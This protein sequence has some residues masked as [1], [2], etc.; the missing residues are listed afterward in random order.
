MDEVTTP[1]QEDVRMLIE[2]NIE[3]MTAL[4]ENS[5][6][7]WVEDLEDSQELPVEEVP[8]GSITEE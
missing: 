8:E 3:K 4:K 6:F 1:N 5:R 2:T 7:E